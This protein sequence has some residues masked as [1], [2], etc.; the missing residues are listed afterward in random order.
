MSWDLY[1]TEVL[2]VRQAVWPISA[3]A[4]DAPTDRAA[5]P[6]S[7]RILFLAEP[8]EVPLA[9]REIF[10]KMLTAMRLQPAEYQVWETSAVDL[11]TREKEIGADWIL[12]CFSKKLA[13][14]LALQR[15]RLSQVTTPHPADCERDPRLKRRVWDDLK[16]TLEK[17]GLSARL[18]S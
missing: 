15:P 1:L 13:D 12:V 11:A 5:D 3:A 9:E 6:A 2:G 18:Q 4:D 7:T 17:A 8:L 14:W 16:R 10:Q